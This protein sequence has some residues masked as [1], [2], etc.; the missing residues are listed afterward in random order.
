MLLTYVFALADSSIVEARYGV[1]ATALPWDVS[2]AAKH[3]LAFTPLLTR[4]YLTI[5]VPSAF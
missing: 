4:A 1:S 3:M 5:Y 2:G